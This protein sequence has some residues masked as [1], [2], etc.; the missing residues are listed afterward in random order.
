MTMRSIS[1][2]FVVYLPQ[3]QSTVFLVVLLQRC[4][5]FSSSSQSSDGFMHCFC[6]AH[7]PIVRSALLFRLQMAFHG[8]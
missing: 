6:S 1:N 4:N 7:F 8:L 5:E 3:S 2:E